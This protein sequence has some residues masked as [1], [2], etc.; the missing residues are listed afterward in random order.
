MARMIPAP[1]AVETKSDAERLL[2][3]CFRQSLGDDYAVFHSVAWQSVT[4]DGRP[5]D[6]EADFV[7]AHPQN[8]I[9]V[10]E[11][12][13]GAIAWNPQTGEWTSTGRSGRVSR[14]HDPFAQAREGKYALRD[15]LQRSAPGLRQFLLGHAVAFPDV[16]VGDD[17]LGPD[18][19]RAIVL[20]RSD[21]ADLAGWVARAMRHCQGESRCD[22]VARLAAHDAL[23]KLLAAPRELRPALWGEIARWQHEL[24]RLTD[25]QFAIL[26]M[27]NRQRRA[28]ICGCAGSGKTLLAVEKATRLAQQGMRVLLTCFN[29]R[30]AAEL[31]GRLAGRA[32]LDVLNFH[33]LCARFAEEAGVLP[34]MGDDEQAF[35]DRQL[36][37]ALLAAV[38]RLGPRFDAIVADEGQDFADEWW[39]PLQ[40]TLRDPDGGILY[41]FYDDNQKLYPRSRQ[42]PISGEPF[43]LT[44]NCRSTQRIHAQVMKFYQGQTQPLSG[45]PEGV[46]PEIVWC[47]GKRPFIP[48]L[49]RVLDRL[50]GEERVPPEHITVLAGARL[51]WLM[52]HAT[53]L[54]PHLTDDP[55]RRGEAIY[56]A[57]V[58]SFKGLESPV[59]IL[60]NV[61]VSWIGDWMKDVPR[62]L[63]VACSRASAHLIVLLARE[64][65]DAMVRQA[66]AE[67]R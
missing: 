18:K 26:N 42:L 32:N 57:T 66:F 46:P 49:Q 7:I 54:R 67:E 47:E 48:E 62:L 53:V 55:A 2:Y 50:I 3:E 52:K 6:G 13:G 28:K 27:L 64:G 35:Y 38:E 59:V 11:V 5:R 41:I 34:V 23:M 56:C 58:H 61:D 4:A 1:I 14:I 20:D 30:L 22:A 12:K 24:I 39:V 40:M 60:T 43:E 65:G 51:E 8:G 19:P 9:L 63:Y 31:Q 17:L 10:I 44:V 37:E 15:A 33:D 21:L 16:V 29:K 45:G 36:P 25:Q